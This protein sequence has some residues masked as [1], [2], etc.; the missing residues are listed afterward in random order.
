MDGWMDGWIDR[1]C[2]FWWGP[3][4]HFILSWQRRWFEGVIGLP[5]AHCALPSKFSHLT[6][7]NRYTHRVPQAEAMKLGFNMFQQKKNGRGKLERCW[8]PGN[9]GLAPFHWNRQ[10]FFFFFKIKCF[11]KRCGAWTD[12]PKTSP[13]I[14]WFHRVPQVFFPFF[15]VSV[16]SSRTAT[17]MGEKHNFFNKPRLDTFG[18]FG[19]W[20]L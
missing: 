13:P 15:P 6:A 8:G 14:P 9:V 11:A 7:C 3:T 16:L 18:M 2:S 10:D 20:P 4:L 12:A 19:I 1:Y 17:L 5:T